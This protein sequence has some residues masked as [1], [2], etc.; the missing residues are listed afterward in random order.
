MVNQES[1]QHLIQPFYTDGGTAVTA[2][3][4]PLMPS[5]KSKYDTGH[6]CFFRNI[7]TEREIKISESRQEIATVL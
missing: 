5:V 4:Y 1:W 6:N 7:S 3:T 2:C